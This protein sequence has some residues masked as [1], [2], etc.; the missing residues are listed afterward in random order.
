MA[1]KSNWGRWSEA[2]E[3]LGVKDRGLEEG[4]WLHRPLVPLWE[5]WLWREWPGSLS[6]PA[7]CQSL[8]FTNLMASKITKWLH[9][10]TIRWERTQT[11]AL[12][13]IIIT[14]SGIR[15]TAWIML[16]ILLQHVGM[17]LQ[18]VSLWV[19][20]LSALHPAFWAQAEVLYCRG[21]R[22]SRRELTL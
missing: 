7:A 11:L 14:S 6:R 5:P 18:F 15:D 3:V 4:A 2:P 10:Q 16:S 9:R 13:D 17:K 8:L 12:G 20:F 19:C 22:R 1:K 21:R